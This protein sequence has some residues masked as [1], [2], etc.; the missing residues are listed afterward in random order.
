MMKKAEKMKIPALFG[1]PTSVGIWES[2]PTGA[3]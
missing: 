2:L 1:V 3:D